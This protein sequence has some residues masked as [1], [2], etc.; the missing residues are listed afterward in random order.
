VLGKKPGIV[1]VDC[2]VGVEACLHYVRVTFMVKEER[3][4]QA[5]DDEVFRCD[6][7]KYV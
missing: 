3:Q 4:Q 5:A 1:P 7:Y 2:D 6:T